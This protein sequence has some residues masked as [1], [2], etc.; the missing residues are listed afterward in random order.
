MSSA[1][2]NSFFFIRYTTIFFLIQILVKLVLESSFIF[3]LHLIL[4]NLPIS[5]NTCTFAVTL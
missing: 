3:L 5:K 1:H 2:L 4:K